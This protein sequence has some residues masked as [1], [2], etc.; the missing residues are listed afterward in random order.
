MICN[1]YFNL[2]FMV[3]LSLVELALISC[4]YV[5]AIIITKNQNH[6][7]YHAEVALVMPNSPT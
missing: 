5:Y 3:L 6:S 7:F 1:L 2:Q 4:P